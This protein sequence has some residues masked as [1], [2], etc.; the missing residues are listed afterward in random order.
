MLRIGINNTGNVRIALYLL[1]ISLTSSP[2][3]YPKNEKKRHATNV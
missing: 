1:I 2:N 3:Y